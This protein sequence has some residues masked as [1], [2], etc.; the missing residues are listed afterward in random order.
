MKWHCRY[1]HLNFGSM[2]ELVDKQLMHGMNI[3]IFDIQ[4]SI[5]MRSKCTQR[6]Y[7]PCETRADNILEIIHAEQN[8]F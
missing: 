4:C 2:K 6:T 1:G 5:C 3:S 8:I 7:S